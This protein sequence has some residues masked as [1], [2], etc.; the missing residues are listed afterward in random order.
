MRWVANGHCSR[1]RQV[2]YKTLDP[3]NETTQ[4]NEE[5]FL[6]FLFLTQMTLLNFHAASRR[7]F[8]A[9]FSKKIP[10]TVDEY[11][12]MYQNINNKVWEEYSSGKI[13]ASKLKT[14]IFKLLLKDISYPADLV[15]DLSK[16]YLERLVELSTLLNGTIEV[17]QQLYLK[18]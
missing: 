4:I 17:I 15:D 10:K 14:E 1:I 16:L 7:A 12:T 11:Y 9:Y 3:C 13:T 5:S 8:I 2:Q 6:R 18:G